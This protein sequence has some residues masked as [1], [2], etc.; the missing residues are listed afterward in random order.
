[1]YL[2]IFIAGSLAGTVTTLLFTA[3]AIARAEQ[4]TF[5]R[6]LKDAQRSFGR[7]AWK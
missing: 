4:D 2:I 5:N 3:K 1:M 7:E 6:C